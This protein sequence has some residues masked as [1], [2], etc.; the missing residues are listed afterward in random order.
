M[1]RNNL[2][3]IV[4][5][6]KMLRRVLKVHECGSHSIRHKYV[7]LRQLSGDEDFYSTDFTKDYSNDFSIDYSKDFAKDYSNDF[8]KD[9]SNDFTKSFTDELTKD[10]TKERACRNVVMTTITNY[11]LSK[12]RNAVF[13]TQLQ[14]EI[15]ELEFKALH[16]IL[17][18]Y[19]LI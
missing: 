4:Q 3:E 19:N 6:K 9:Y 11:N 7:P 18:K 12:R 1:I 16:E 5:K 2:V 14:K 8:T 10:F 13:C 17:D 15:K